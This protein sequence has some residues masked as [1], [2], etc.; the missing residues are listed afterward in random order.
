MLKKIT[1][2]EE[3]HNI[4]LESFFFFFFPELICKFSLVLSVLIP[5]HKGG[6]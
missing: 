1:T 6:L 2:P 3:K 5:E 4:E